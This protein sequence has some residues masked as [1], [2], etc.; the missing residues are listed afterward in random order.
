MSVGQYIKTKKERMKHEMTHILIILTVLIVIVYIA[1]RP[2]RHLYSTPS[3]PPSSVRPVIL[4]II[5]SLMDQPLQ[6]MIRQ[7]KAPALQFL[8]ERGQYYPKMVSAFPTM[9]VC[10]DTTLLTGVS[11]NQHQVFG[12]THYCPKRKRVIN[13]G[14]GMKEC[15]SFGVKNVLIDSL[16][17]LNQE[18]MSSDVKTIHEAYDGPTASINALVYRGYNRH[19][20]H[21][22]LLAKLF[23]LP[24]EIKTQGPEIF[25]FGSLH[26]L[27]AANQYGQ[28]W[29]RYGM[30]D[31]FSRME[32]TPLIENKQL[33]PFTILYLPSND[34]YL[35]AHGPQE[36]KGIEKADRELQKILDGFSS[37]EKAID[38]TTF[39]ILG[40]S[41]HTQT[42]PDHSV[43]YVYLRQVLSNYSIMPTKQIYP[44]KEDQLV[45]CVN[46][47]MG[48]IYILDDQLETA[49]IAKIVQQDKRIDVIA[50]RDKET[51]HI[52][53]GVMDGE[54]RYKETGPYIDEYNQ[55]WSLQG[56]FSILDLTS[57][58]DGTIQYGEYPDALSR[59][60][61]VMNTAEKVLV[62]TCSPGYEL[63][64][65]AS[66]THT[67]GS[68]GSLHYHD[69]HIPMIVTGTTQRPLS[70][71]IIDLK[72]WI[73]S[74][75][76]E[77]N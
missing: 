34:D 51:T 13:Y 41:G 20:L 49:Q 23:G 63:V 2:T 8:I 19:T 58:Q 43:S 18:I 32:I 9:S 44:H 50:W 52:I 42:L 68:H 3:I 30:N 45:L 24:R 66:P 25:S 54:L 37:W 28:P 15:L 5:D 10:I 27:N 29:L 36:T 39:V 64:D 56:D 33:P 22:P 6:E 62:I 77:N 75:L 21:L 48:Y 73:L 40:D 74:L 67:G 69:S 35:H 65:T 61:G 11:P 38:T 55:S 59:I 12:L 1:F 71:R 17:N 26:Q 46:E 70:L 16:K 72:E 7:G 4:I 57:N 53:S 76:K 47:R 14:T 60:N 31:R